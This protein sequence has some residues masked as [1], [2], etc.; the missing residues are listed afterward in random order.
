MNS[1]HKIFLLLVVVLA[2]SLSSFFVHVFTAEWLPT[3][4]GGQMDGRELKSSW[5]VRYAAGVTSVE[6]GVA[7]V[8]LYHLSRNAILRFGKFRAAIIYSI[9]LAAIHGAF[10]RQ[11]LMDYLIGNPL[12]VVVVQNLF[13]WLVWLLM[14]FIVVYGY[15]ITMRVG[16]NK[17]LKRTP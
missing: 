7:A 16:A 4:I 11:P 13:N 8:A 12:Q 3:W 2:A 1:W 5:A 10:I 14:A 9:L 15:E 17:S 6:Y